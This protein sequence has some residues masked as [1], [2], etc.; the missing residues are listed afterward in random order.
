MFF[1][2]IIEAQPY[3]LFPRNLDFKNGDNR[4]PNAAFRY[5]REKLDPDSNHESIVLEPNLWSGKFSVK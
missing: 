5:D 2:S 4:Y 3:F 1:A